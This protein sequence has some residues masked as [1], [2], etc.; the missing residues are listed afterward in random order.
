MCVCRYKT[1][2]CP[3]LEEHDRPTLWPTSHDVSLKV[4]SKFCVS[5]EE[6]FL[7]WVEFKNKTAAKI[8]SLQEQHT[9]I[10][11]SW[12]HQKSPCVFQSR[13]LLSGRNSRKIPHHWNFVEICSKCS[14]P[15]LLISRTANSFNGADFQDFVFQLQ[16]VLPALV[17]HQ[18][19]SY[20]QWSAGFV[21]G[22]DS[23][24]HLLKTKSHIKI[25]EKCQWPK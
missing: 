2:N 23:S 19:F 18:S 22:N 6:F 4:K 17:N 16:F 12:D 3:L 13:P 9:E 24:I 10:F 15:F 7:H 25:K 21:Q 11:H 20:L 1:V 8:P 14:F 5:I